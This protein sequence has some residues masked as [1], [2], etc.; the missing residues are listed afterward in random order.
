M[1]I[2]VQVVR[3]NRKGLVPVVFSLA[4]L[5]LF[6]VGA[7]ASSRPSAAELAA[8]TERGR[9]LAEY[10]ASAWHATDAVLATHPKEGSSNRYIAHKT[11]PDWVVDFGG[12]ARRATSSLWYPRQFQQAA[13]IRS[14]ASTQCVRIRAGISQR[15]KG[16][17]RP[18]GILVKRTARTI[19]SC[20]RRRKAACTCT[21]IRP[22]SKRGFIRWER[23]CRDQK[24]LGRNAV[25][26]WC[27]AAGRHDELA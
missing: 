19:S 25:L 17:R 22:R 3:I 5:F 16:L 24:V 20:F 15:P 8:I 2:S 27:G 21:C 11:D 23:M 26:P 14:R 13:N 10:D 18:C 1:L 6:S 7:S 4:V 12:S 9:L